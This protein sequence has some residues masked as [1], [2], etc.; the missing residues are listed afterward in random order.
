MSHDFLSV[1]Q[2]FAIPPKLFKKNE[3]VAR[4]VR[5]EEQHQI[6]EL[7]KLEARRGGTLTGK[8]ITV[9]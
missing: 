6:K 3:A 1:L 9:K 2:Y 4:L 8:T 5:G 7:D